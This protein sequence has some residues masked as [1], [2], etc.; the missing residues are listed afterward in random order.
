MIQTQEVR[1]VWQTDVLRE[2]GIISGKIHLEVQPLYLHEIVSSS[3]L[4]PGGPPSESIE[5]GR[6]L[7]PRVVL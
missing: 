4:E 6:E 7:A 1:H 2:S 5:H 3:A